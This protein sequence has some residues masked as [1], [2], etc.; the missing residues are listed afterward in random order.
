MYKKTTKGPK[1][2][3]AVTLPGILCQSHVFVIQTLTGVTII[4][5]MC[6]YFLLFTVTISCVHLI[7]FVPYIRDKYH[8]AVVLPRGRGKLYTKST[9]YT[10]ALWV[11]RFK[12]RLLIRIYGILIKLMKFDLRTVQNYTVQVNIFPWCAYDA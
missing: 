1:C 3:Q 11:V 12:C 5:T 7:W 9:G 8:G 2:H 6:K 4:F 10:G